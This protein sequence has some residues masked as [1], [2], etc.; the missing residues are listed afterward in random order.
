MAESAF[1]PL[2][3]LFECALPL[4]VSVCRINVEF[5]AGGG[6]TG[7]ARKQ[8]IADKSQKLKDNRHKKWKEGDRP[9]AK[10]NKVSEGSVKNLGN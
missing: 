7:E 8:K 10:K 5:T 3:V 9:V 6:G 4:T 1:S 2:F